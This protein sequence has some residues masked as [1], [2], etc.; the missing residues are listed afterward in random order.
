MPCTRRACRDRCPSASGPPQ[1]WL[2]KARNLAPLR[3]G[4][5]FPAR[6]E[7]AITLLRNKPPVQLLP[8][9]RDPHTVLRWRTGPVG[10][11]ARPRFG[12]FAAQ[13]RRYRGIIVDDGHRFLCPLAR[14]SF[15]NT[16]GP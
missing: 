11:L 14:F 5:L 8:I 12:L 6:L 2:Q 3:R 10:I 9:D 13:L 4:F 7:P 15:I 1:P 16:A